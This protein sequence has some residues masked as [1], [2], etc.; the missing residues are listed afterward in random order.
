MKHIIITGHSKGLGA[1]ITQQLIGED[2]HI[3]GI[4][5]TDN[6]T[7]HNLAK[8]KSGRI[9]FYPCDLAQKDLLSE[10]MNSVFKTI[11]Q[12]S[13]ISGVYLINNAGVIDPI[14]TIE[15]L[16]HELI[17]KHLLINL[18][19]PLILTNEFLK[20]TSKLETVKRIMNISSGAAVNP[21]HGWSI[22]CTG[23]AALDMFTRC[24]GTE[25]KDKNFPV[26]AMAVAPG[27]IDTDMQ[28]TIRATPDGQF[29]HKQKFVELKETGQLVKPEI[30][31]E[32]L[33][34]LLFSDEFE[35]GGITDIRH[36]Y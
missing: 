36:L 1:G 19:A 5:R 27:I 35:N 28:S 13:D 6:P 20:H 12:S 21:Y 30:A 4:S 18:H 11:H 32:K 26:E 23:K 25:Q 17:E 2:T 15:T 29:I 34:E 10:V 7:L 16:D 8:E 9:S 14:G 22:Y 33:K 24:I 31:G 3:H